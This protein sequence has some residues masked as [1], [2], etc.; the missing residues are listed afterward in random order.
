M[1]KVRLGHADA[2]NGGQDGMGF[3]LRQ[4]TFVVAGEHAELVLA[5]A[6]VVWWRAVGRRPAGS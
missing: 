6:L 3:S 1:D 2:P 5:V 4:A